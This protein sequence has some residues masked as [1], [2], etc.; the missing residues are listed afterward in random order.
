M[1]KQIVCFIIG[2]KPIITAHPNS[3][4]VNITSDHESLSLACKAEGAT[5]YCWERQSGTIPSGATGKNN[6]TLTLVNIKP[7]DAGNYRCAV[8][9]KSDKSYSEY[10]IV[11]IKGQLLFF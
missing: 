6:Q 2:A 10:S 4:V 9:N 7:V 8:G 1:N 5:S 11:M 3:A